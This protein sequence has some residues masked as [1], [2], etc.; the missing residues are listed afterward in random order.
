[1]SNLN[2]GPRTD[3]GKKISSRNAVKVGIYTD[4]LLDGE[5]PQEIEDLR[6][7]LVEE[8]GL[9]GTQ[10]ELIARD[11]VLAELKC[12]RLLRAQKDL[13]DAQMQMNDSRYEFAKQAGI[14]SL[15]RDQIPGWYFGQ[16][17]KKKAKAELI[18]SAVNEA[19]HF[20]SNHSLQANLQARTLYPNLW[21]VVMGPNAI[22]PNQ[23]L[24]EKLA[25][26]FNKTSPAANLQAFVEHYLE[27]ARYDYKWGENVDRYEAVLRG[28]RAK[29]IMDLS[30]R[31]DW[32]KLDNQL[33]R[34]RLELT[35]LAHAIKREKQAL[36][37]AQ[38]LDALPHGDAEPSKELEPS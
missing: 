26:R 16:D 34:R 6:Q 21:I 20:K 38:V 35:Q 12:G 29:L 11:Y 10:G 14:S 17:S 36:L 9:E 33:H 22:N 37:N 8:W 23:T 32:V 1:M 19:A 24:C 13:A 4:V 28:Q 3:Q 18:Y 5:D 30:T 31:A 25:V 27:T 2:G 7:S 15:E